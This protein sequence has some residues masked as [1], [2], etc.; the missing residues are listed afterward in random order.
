MLIAY[1][2]G[3]LLALFAMGWFVTDLWESLGAV[4]VMVVAAGYGAL[5][6]L[7]ARV[8]EREGFPMAR[9]LAVH[10]LA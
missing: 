1:G 8:L 5:F 4:G 10:W 6:L 9:G 3:G 2:V 7:V